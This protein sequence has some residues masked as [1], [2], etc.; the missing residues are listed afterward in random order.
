MHQYCS[1]AEEEHAGSRRTFLMCKKNRK[2]N[3]VKKKK[4]LFCWLNLFCWRSQIWC[5]WLLQFGGKWWLL[6][7]FLNFSDFPQNSVYVILANI[8]HTKMCKKLFFLKFKYKM[9][10]CLNILCKILAF[11]KK[12]QF[13]SINYLREFLQ[14]LKLPKYGFHFFL[15]FLTN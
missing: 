3:Y 9:Y 10:F 8:W 15:S 11:K 4:V 6:R 2:K 5:F 13:F 14:N 12:L 1:T 7:C